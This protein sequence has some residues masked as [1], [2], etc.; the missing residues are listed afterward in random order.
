MSTEKIYQAVLK[1]AGQCYRE[2]P[3][4]DHL[5]IGAGS[6]RLIQQMQASFG[7][8]SSACDYTDTLMALPGQKVHIIDLNKDKHLPFADASFD[9]V[10]AT[11]ILEH[12]EDYRR[13]IRQIYRVLRPGGICILSTPN[14]LN[15]NSRVRYLCFGFPDLFG[16]LPFGDRQIHLTSGH[17]NPL[18]YFYLVHALLEAGFTSLSPSFDKYQRSGVLKLFLFFIP[19]KLFG[20]WIFQREIAKYHTIDGRN[21]D[22]IR[23]MNSIGILLGRTIILRARKKDPIDRSY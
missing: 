22:L 4:Q 14:V 21:A 5:D 17:I 19:I 9:I 6:G 7:T 13:I 20:K 10:T 12:L 23:E 11:E 15:I 18:S 1:A 8:I 2:T 3:F 16:P